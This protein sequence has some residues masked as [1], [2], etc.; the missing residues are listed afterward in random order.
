MIPEEQAP[1][2]EVLLSFEINPAARLVSVCGSGPAQAPEWI[3]LFDRVLASDLH[4]PGYNFLIDR[5]EITSVPSRETVDRIIGYYQS[6]AQ[7]FGR[8]RIAS[9][10]LSDPAYGMTRMASVFAERTTVKVGVFRDFAEA[11]RWLASRS[12]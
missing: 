9:V 4:Q 6:H 1:E 11:R 10:T 8:C 5:R 2:G 7:Q 3:E 12:S